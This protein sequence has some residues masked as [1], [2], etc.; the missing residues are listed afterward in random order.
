[1]SRLD[2][3][4][5]IGVVETYY[6]WRNKYGRLGMLKFNGVPKEHF[7]LYLKAYE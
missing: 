1:M 5:Q 7:R 3:M 6:R 4:R 2:A